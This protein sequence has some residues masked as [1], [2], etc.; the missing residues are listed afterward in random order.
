MLAGQYALIISTIVDQKLATP[1][2]PGQYALIIST[3]VDQERLL[4]SATAGQYALIISTIVDK[5][6]ESRLTQAGASMLQ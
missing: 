2:Y 1:A 5:Q 6:L 4:Y 3:I